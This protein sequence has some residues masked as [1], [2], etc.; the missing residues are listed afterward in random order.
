MQDSVI[1]SVSEALERQ[2][3]EVFAEHHLVGVSVGIVREGELVWKRGFGYADLAS[4]R[5]ADADTLYRVASITKTFT[6]TA[7]IQLRDEGRLDLDDPV[8]RHI[9]EFAA[10]RARKGRVEG[11]T[12]RRMLC[13]HSGLVGEIPGDHWETLRFPAMEEMLAALPDVE[14]VLE[15][16]A[17]FKYSNLA[18]ALLGEVVSRVSGQP[19]TEYVRAQIL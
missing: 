8:V 4:G 13:H 17:A 11:V 19:Y 3:R 2:V 1:E 10:V 12:L 7:I 18:F 15:Q 5:R 14:I 16:D 9:P 6:G